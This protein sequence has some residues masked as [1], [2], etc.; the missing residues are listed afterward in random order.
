MAHQTGAIRATALPIAV[1]EEWGPHPGDL[2]F[3]SPPTLNNQEI[4]MTGSP[5]DDVELMARFGIIRVPTH[6]YHYREWRYSNL[7]DALA[8]A[9]R[10]T[11][12]S[13]TE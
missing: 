10:D 7:G 8:Q 12:Q 2:G 6:I 4:S 5:T 3:T 1:S 9:R 11:A 13:V